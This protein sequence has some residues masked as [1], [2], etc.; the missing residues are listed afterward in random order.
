[1]SGT[2]RACLVQQRL[3]GDTSVL[4]KYIRINIRKGKE[5]V[6]LKDNIGSGGNGYKLVMNKLK[7]E[8]RN[9]L[10]TIT[11]R[12][13]S[14]LPV[15]VDINYFLQNR[16]QGREYM[17][18]QPVVADAGID[19]FLSDKEQSLEK[20]YYLRWG[21][22]C[23]LPFAVNVNAMLTRV[24]SRTKA[25]TPSCCHRHMLLTLPCSTVQGCPSRSWPRQR[26]RT[27]EVVKTYLRQKLNAQCFLGQGTERENISD[28]LTPTALW[29]VTRLSRI[30][31]A[32]LPRKA[33][34]FSDLAEGWA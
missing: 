12:L 19:V 7:L 25:W 16:A 31:L 21:L 9:N 23:P 14:S 3:T 10:L 20:A 2:A 24:I 22:S 1:M 29:I 6:K 17:T 27:H 34:E 28:L 30:V 13:W 32:P 26:D 18:W 15:G 33:Q 11:V 5:L 4:C 8:A